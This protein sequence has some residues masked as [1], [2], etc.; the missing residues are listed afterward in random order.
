[1]LQINATNSLELSFEVGQMESGLY[2]LSI[3]TIKG[4]IEW[5]SFIK[6]KLNVY[7][8]LSNQIK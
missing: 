7:Y 5:M 4:K 8:Q 1:M 2:M 6:N 3:E